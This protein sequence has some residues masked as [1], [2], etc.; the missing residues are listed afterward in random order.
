[1]CR[2]QTIYYS[3]FNSIAAYILLPILPQNGLYFAA[4][5][6]VFCRKMEFILPQNRK[7]FG[8]KWKVIWPKMECVLVQN[9]NNAVSCWR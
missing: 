6:I 1:M 5:W 7:R 8:P 3:V 9:A 4:K 2:T